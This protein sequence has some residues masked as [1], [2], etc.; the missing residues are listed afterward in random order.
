MSSHQGKDKGPALEA[1]VLED[2]LV[3]AEGKPLPRVFVPRPAVP[4]GEPEAEGAENTIEVSKIVPKSGFI[5]STAQNLDLLLAPRTLAQLVLCRGCNYH[6]T[7]EYRTVHDTK[8]STTPAG[9]CFS[10]FDCSTTRILLL[11]D[12]KA[13]KRI[14]GYLSVQVSTTGTGTLHGGAMELVLKISPRKGGIN[15]H[16]RYFHVPQI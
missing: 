10:A 8:Y 15:C 14:D 6:E 4:G 3:D 2:A 1:V 12:C 7:G 16:V 9:L 5:D 13:L 11:P